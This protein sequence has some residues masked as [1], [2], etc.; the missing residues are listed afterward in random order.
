MTALELAKRLGV[1]DGAVT[2]LESS[3]LLEKTPTESFDPEKGR[4]LPQ[5]ARALQLAL[6][7]KE[8]YAALGIPE[9]V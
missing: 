8:K 1:P 7:T 3:G 2:A 4:G 9:E 5:L 6:G